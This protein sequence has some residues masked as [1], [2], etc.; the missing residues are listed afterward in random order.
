[1]TNKLNILI[2]EVEK[3]IENLKEN[4]RKELN[5]GFPNNSDDMIEE[6][7][8]GE[9]HDS[10]Y[11]WGNPRTDI[12]EAKLQAYQEALKI[13]ENKKM[14]KGE[15]ENKTP[16]NTLNNK[17]L[18]S[19]FG[20]NPYSLSSTQSLSHKGIWENGYEIGKEE[21]DKEIMEIINNLDIKHGQTITH[22]KEGNICCQGCYMLGLKDGKQ[23]R[24]KEEIK[25]L[26]IL[27]SSNSYNWID[28]IKERIQ[29][30]KQN[31]L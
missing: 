4:R 15:S 13:M 14:N 6:Y 28:L 29:T 3:E 2:S 11:V 23:E 10:E 27:N 16:D 18:A 22:D 7:L 20:I 31:G 8:I 17:R 21:R 25:F 19:L 30:L 1:M 9:R 5:E 26:E 12:L 24:D